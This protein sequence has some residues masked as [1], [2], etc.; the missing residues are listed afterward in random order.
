MKIIFISQ[1]GKPF[2]VRLCFPDGGNH[3]FLE[4]DRG[5][6]GLEN[7][8]GSAF[9]AGGRRKGNRTSERA[10]DTLD[11]CAVADRLASAM[12]RWTGVKATTK[13]T[14]TVELETE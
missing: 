2:K 9:P 10:Y 3:E 7:V 11:A 6:P 13:V 12:R 8:L 1:Q 14:L 5:L 4:T